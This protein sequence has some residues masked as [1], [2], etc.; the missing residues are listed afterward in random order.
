[1]S[2]QLLFHCQYGDQQGWGHLVRCSAL[3]QHAREQGLTTHLWSAGD[4]ASLPVEIQ[5]SFDGLVSRFSPSDYAALVVDNPEA[6]RHE[7]MAFWPAGKPIIVIDD[8]CTRDLSYA[9]VII[10]P[11]LNAH[12]LPYPATVR[13][14]CLGADYA[15]LRAPFRQLAND[16]KQRKGMV[17]MIGGT[18]VLNLVPEILD[19]LTDTKHPFQHI[20]IHLITPVRKPTRQAIEN[21]LKQSKRI[22]WHRNAH[23][24]QIASL[25]RQSRVGITACGGTTYEMAACKLP[26]LGIVVADNQQSF[27]SAIQHAWQ[28]PIISG[29]TVTG[30]IICANLQR[31]LQAPTPDFRIDGHGVSR[32]LQTIKKALRNR[33]AL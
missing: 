13:A 18:D 11:A 5:N 17:I 9:D 3:A 10:N 22:T 8:T 29:H 6:E 4:K 21:Y 32:A 1:M 31:L 16:C 2:T 25:F 28:L 23:A 30:A 27:S 14:T 24:A 33:S 26:F 15:L 19:C 12:T 20:P 7:V